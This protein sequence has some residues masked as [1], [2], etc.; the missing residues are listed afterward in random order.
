MAKTTYRKKTINGK[1]Y[2]FYRLRHE[3]LK[4]PKD[5]YGKTVHELEDKIKALKHDLDYGIKDNKDTFGKFFE[6][7]LFNI[8]YLS[9][10][11]SSKTTY[12]SLYTTHIKDNAICKVKLKEITAID[13]QKYFNG[14]KNK[15][16]SVATIKNLYKL[17]KP[18][19]TYAYNN[20]FIIKDFAKAIILPKES[21]AIRRARNDKQKALNDEQVILFINAIK[22]HKMEALFLTDLYT[23]LRQGE[24]LAL[25]WDDIN[26]E[27]MYIDVNKNVTKVPGID[28]EEGRANYH[29]VVQ[30]PKTLSSI[31]KVYF[32]SDLIPVLQAHREAQNKK[33]AF[34]GEL[35]DSSLNLVFCNS[36]GNY[37]DAGN[38]RKQ[39][40][41]VTTSIGAPDIT[42]HNLRHSFATML[43]EVDGIKAKTVQE[44]LGHSNISTTLD[45]YTHVH[46]SIKKDAANMLNTS[47]RGK[48]EGK[49]F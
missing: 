35:Y 16:V 3:S 24:I 19:I 46:E 34:L 13:F 12:Y 22:G 40:K 44:I 1:E 4:S 7:W 41:K 14:L 18:S 45:I 48:L 36:K 25:T 20:N 47:I 37:L 30:T 39:L 27:E 21:E 5:L 31:R 32:T 42:F 33:K 9:I 10:K 11:E 29:Y 17:I 49:S 43:F 15:G 23:G 6:D 26:F 28:V 38:V 8:H 2:Y